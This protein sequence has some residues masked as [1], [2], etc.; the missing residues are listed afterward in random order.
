MRIDICEIR[1][2]SE[3]VIVIELDEKER[4]LLGVMKTVGVIIETEIERGREFAT[5]MIE[6]RFLT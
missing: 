1:L 4:T 6:V 3:E 2:K 5:D